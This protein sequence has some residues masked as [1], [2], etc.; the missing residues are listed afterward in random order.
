[1]FKLIVCTNLVGAIGKDNKLL[2][3]IPN[4]MDNFKRFTDGNTVIMGMN[5]YLSLPNQKPL[6][7]RVNIVITPNPK[8]CTEKFGDTSVYFV[9][10]ING[11][12]T[13]MRHL[14][15]KNEDVFIIGGSSI[16][17][18]FLEENLISEAYITLVEDKTEGDS[19]FPLKDFS[20]EKWKKIYESGFQRHQELKYKFLI[21]KNK[22]DE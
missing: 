7:N 20:Y 22:D 8:L 6:K 4:D 2:Y 14:N 9:N 21:Y 1:M 12:I 15:V 3:H 18:A 5:T 13:L 16:Y 11:A 19:Y 10:S 17:K